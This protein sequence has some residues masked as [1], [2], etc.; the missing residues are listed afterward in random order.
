MES[1][2]EEISALGASSARPR[3]GGSAASSPTL[4]LPESFANLGDE[5]APRGAPLARQLESEL[6]ATHERRAAEREAYHARLAAARRDAD[7]ARRQADGQA[8]ELAR[9]TEALRDRRDAIDDGFRDGLAYAVDA[10]GD[11]AATASVRALVDELR[12]RPVDELT[13]R[14]LA[15]VRVVEASERTQTARL[16]SA[17]AAL[18][19][20]KRRD[21]AERAHERLRAE[22][23]GLA[24]GA[25]Q[26]EQLLR[27]DLARIAAELEHAR[28]REAE[29]AE[30]LEAGRAA[31]VR[32][33]RVEA[34]RARYIA[35]NAELAAH[36]AKATDAVRSTAA[37]GADCARRVRDAEAAC[38]LARQEAGHQRDVAN[39]EAKRA[40]AAEYRGLR[41]DEA[42]EEKRVQVADL[43]RRL[44]LEGDAFRE[45]LEARTREVAAAADARVEALR[46][47]RET[48]EQREAASLRE[49][50][51][52]A[53]EDAR[54]E[55]EARVAAEAEV[56][57][58]R[59]QA[60]EAE[61]RRVAEM[62]EAAA[63][64]RVL[65]YELA[66]SATRLRA[67][68]RD[69]DEARLE[70]A[71][72]REQVAVRAARGMGGGVSSLP[73]GRRAL[74]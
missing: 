51:A 21:A 62:A 60:A 39:A 2:D 11:E 23:E 18:D 47:E 35:E 42:V 12:A 4:S 72:L 44:A 19:A 20:A 49:A 66:A 41:A 40:D 15:T 59:S 3:A 73:P 22:H 1:D 70:N 5:P 32:L 50:R 25:A 14:E 9:A 74:V 69:R 13:L 24:H 71:M 34:D 29:R 28:R 10:G 16:E 17:R 56:A 57:G 67:A 26:R 54:R 27:D 52:D 64:R 8:V 61:A 68:E 55:R 46:R 6:A 65:A 31:S 45:K 48:F 30:A 58:A 36:Q 37:A 43:Q 7:A 38:E 33:A 63:E 53:V